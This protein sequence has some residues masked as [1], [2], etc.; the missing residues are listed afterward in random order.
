[1]AKTIYLISPAP[2]YPSYFNFVGITGNISQWAHVREVARE[3]RER[4]K[5]V[6]I[7]GPQATLRAEAVRPHCDI[8][9]R[10]ELEEIATELFDDLRS[11]NWKAEYAGT[12]A[13]LSKAPLPRL[14]LYP[15]DRTLTGAIQMSRGC[16]FRCEFCEITRYHGRKQRHKTVSRVVQEL[17]QLY[18][19]AMSTPIPVFTAVTL[20]AHV[21]TPLYE[22]FEQEDRIV[23]KGMTRE[24]LFQGLRRLINKLYE[25]K[26]YA[27]R[28][29]GKLPR[30]GLAETGL[31]VRL[32]DQALARPR[33]A[34]II[35]QQAMMYMQFRH[36]FQLGGYW[37][38][39]L[40][41]L[42]EPWQGN[43]AKGFR[44]GLR[45]GRSRDTMGRSGISDSP[46]RVEEQRW[47]LIST[48]ASPRSSWRR[49]NSSRA[50]E[51]PTST[52]RARAMTSFEARSNR[53]CPRRRRSPK[54]RSR[55]CWA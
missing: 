52:K 20:F 48:D 46:R 30:L 49:R 11:G 7:G 2:D 40:A 53:C 3:F 41:K 25:P 9:V 19:F 23:P 34:R 37:K 16:P 32:L 51:P 15:N 50:T 29:L 8:L 10:G 43:S 27:L 33:L 1:M 44:G 54:R 39:R 28:I 24:E 31:T 17:E 36:I 38:P 5:V 6:L 47:I 14:D 35:V 13:D 22:R 12:E 18:E 21:T 45:S 42:E 26:A 4:G 55:T